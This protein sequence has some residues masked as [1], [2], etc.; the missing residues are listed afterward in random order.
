MAITELY[1]AQMNHT[2]VTTVKRKLKKRNK[3]PPL[4]N[5]Y[6]RRWGADG[7]LMTSCGF[8]SILNQIIHHRTKSSSLPSS[9]DWW[10][11]N[12]NVALLRG[13]APHS[14]VIDTD[15]TSHSCRRRSVQR[16]RL[17]KACG[18]EIAALPA[19]SDGAQTGTRG[20]HGGW[21][22]LKRTNMSAAIDWD[23]FSETR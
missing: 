13:A 16:S 9:H 12:S 6:K 4:W 15:S 8:C 21:S 17:Q 1:V 7:D 10:L 20:I 19:R 22:A 14:C 3:Q 5:M 2:I 18:H 11:T 23:T